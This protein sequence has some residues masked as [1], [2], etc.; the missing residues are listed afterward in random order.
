MADLRP[1]A[2]VGPRRCTSATSWSTR[3][4]APT[5][6]GLRGRGHHRVPRQGPPDRRRVRRGGD[7]RQQRDRG[8]R[9]E[10]PALFPGTPVKEADEQAVM[11]IKVDFDLVSP[12]PCARRWRPRSWPSST[13]TT[14]SSLK[15]E[16]TTPREHRRTSSA[17]VAPA[18][19]R[20]SPWRTEADEHQ[21]GRQGRDRHRL[22][23]GPGPR[24]GPRPRGRRSPDRPQRPA[25]RRRR[26]GRGD[27]L[28]AAA[29]R[30]SSPAT[31]GSGPRPTRCSRPRSRATARSTSSSTTPA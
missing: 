18:R 24:R 19:A 13:T 12:T 3:R 23:R 16:E 9:P 27:P 29:R 28:R 2:A 17:R 26:H 8:D 5:C 14:S 4:C 1:H 31:S 21:P 7:R 22:R 10:R 30:R 20:R 15:T 25:R 6:P 11:K